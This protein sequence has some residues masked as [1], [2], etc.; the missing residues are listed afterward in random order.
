METPVE[1]IPLN[2]IR[3]GTPIPAEINEVAWVCR[4]CD[5]GQQ[6]GEDGLLPLEI[7]YAHGLQP[8]KKGYPFWVCEGSVTLDRETYGVFGKKTKDALRF[9]EQPRQFIIP[10][11]PYPLD[12]FSR[13]GVQWLQNHPTLQPGPAAEFVPVTVS[14]A[15]VPAWAE[16]LVMALEAER[17][18][19]VKTVKFSL[20]LTRPHLWILP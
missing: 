12:E 8:S 11:Y 16:F 7:H 15:D 14:A 1:L 4:Q 18:D 5:Q 2:C 10:A 19:K 17:K 13:R 20:Q 3:C 9:W 6:L